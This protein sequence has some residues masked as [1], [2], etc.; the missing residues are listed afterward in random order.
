MSRIIT[1]PENIQISIAN[2]GVWSFYISCHHIVDTNT[3]FNKDGIGIR[4]GAKILLALENKLPGEEIELS[5]IEWKLL[6]EAFEK[7]EHGYII[8]VSIK[9]TK[10]ELDGTTTDI[11]K[12]LNIPNR[13]FLTYI[14]AV[15]DARIK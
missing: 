5:D 7:P 3:I 12:E 14:D 11:E 15:A 10:E 4:A 6:N 13:M 9:E 1:I 2:V 8:P